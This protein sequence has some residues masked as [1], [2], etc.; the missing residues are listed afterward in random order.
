MVKQIFI[1]IFLAMSFT[2]FAMT[3]DTT[4]NSHLPE[5]ERGYA[6]LKYGDYDL[7]VEAFEKVI[8]HAPDFA[9]AHSGLAY[10]Y[11][12]LGKYSE[13]VAEYER[14]RILNP[15]LTQVY[16]GLGYIA[17]RRG[18]LDLAI[19]HYNKAIELQPDLA[20]A[21]HNL[22]LIYAQQGKIAEAFEEQKRAVS[23]DPESAEAHFHLGLLYEKLERWNEA[24]EH[25]QQA[26]KWNSVFAEP[27]YQLARIYMK[28]KEQELAQQNMEH[29]RIRKAEADA[30]A[31]AEEAVFMA[32]GTAKSDALLSL[33]TVYLKQNK[34]QEAKVQFQRV[35]LRDEKRADAYAGLGHVALERN[36]YHTAIQNYKRALELGMNTAEAHHNLGIALMQESFF[37]QTFSKSLQMKKI[38]EAISHFHKAVALDTTPLPPSPLPKGAGGCDKGDEKSAKSFLMLGTLYATQNQFE[39]A[40][41]N[42][43]KVIELEPQDA[44][45]YHSL[46]YLYGQHDTDLQ[47]AVELAQKATQLAP[48]SALYFNTL[49]W[50]LY[51]QGKWREAETAIKK[52]I[53][54]DPDNTL[55]QEGLSEIQKK[56][57]SDD[58]D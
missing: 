53:E 42:F 18:N 14:A 5:Y 44:I 48:E 40:K 51:K 6:C 37:D 29:F 17:Y 35:L 11:S 7:A 34:F 24:V 47:I 13:A 50:L 2:D 54:I 30:I 39:L 3:S 41:Q 31:T 57:R 43:L 32:E 27:Y 9:E 15:E 33:A 56:V 12:Q 52:A 21:H 20:E 58:T 55:Y 23:A 16:I 38:D 8:Q 45:A 10:A 1:T 49:S 36:Q 4:E 28:R 46:A 19:E 22:G 25:H 26:L